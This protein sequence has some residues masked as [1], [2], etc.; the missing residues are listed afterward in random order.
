MIM[1]K[2]RFIDLLKNENEKD[3]NIV[4]ITVT[5]MIILEFKELLVNA[6]TFLTLISKIKK[7]MM[8]WDWWCLNCWS[9]S[10]ILKNV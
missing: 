6:K 1:T 8:K 10:L 3:E 7:K 9:F 2:L 5:K 4:E